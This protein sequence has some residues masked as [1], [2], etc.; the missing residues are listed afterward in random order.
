MY[1]HLMWVHVF[2]LAMYFLNKTHKNHYIFFTGSRPKVAITT[3]KGL[4]QV[5]AKDTM[6][7]FKAVHHTSPLTNTQTQAFVQI[8]S[9]LL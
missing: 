8:W 7:D 5:L 9:L 2:H 4:D 6:T 3:V 1:H